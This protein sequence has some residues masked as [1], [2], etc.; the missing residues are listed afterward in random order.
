MDKALYRASLWYC[1]N[2]EIVSALL[3]KLHRRKKDTAMHT[4]IKGDA[5]FAL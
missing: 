4:L 1:R 5:D 3:V 2:G